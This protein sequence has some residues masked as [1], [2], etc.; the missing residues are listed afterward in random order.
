MKKK[1]YLPQRGL[2]Y[3]QDGGDIS[4]SPKREG[5]FTEFA[6]SIGMD[7]QAAA[8]HV[9][10]HKDKYSPMRVK[11]ANFARNAAKFKHADG[12]EAH[13]PGSIFGAYHYALPPALALRLTGMYDVP[14]PDCEPYLPKEQYGGISTEG[15]RSNSPDRF[16]PYNIIPSGNISM[17]N[18]PHPVFG[19]DNMGTQQMMYPGGEYQFPGQTVFELPMR[20]MGGKGKYQQG[21]NTSPALTR[22]YVDSVFNANQNLNWVNRYTHPDN[23]PKINNP[24]GSYSTHMMV[25]SDNMVYP[26][27]VQGSDGKLIKLNP[28]DAYNYA[29]KTGTF[30]KFPDEKDAIEFARNG[31]KAGTQYKRDGARYQQGGQFARKKYYRQ[32]GGS[33]ESQNAMNNTNT[34]ADATAAAPVPAYKNPN[35]PELSN[36]V[37][38]T[39]Y[40]DYAI[41]SGQSPIGTPRAST[42]L[43]KASQV[44]GS[45]D[46]ARKLLDSIH[47]FSQRNDVAKL[48]PA[49][50]IDL[51]YNT[52]HSNDAD[53]EKFKSKVKTLGYSP[54]DYFNNS[55]DVDI[56]KL[57]NQSRPSNLS[58]TDDTGMVHLTDLANYNIASGSNPLQN[59]YGRIFL[60]SAGDVLGKGA[61][62]KMMDSMYLFSQRDDIK[63]LSPQDRLNLYY[64]TLNSSDSDVNAFKD[65]VKKLGTS[66]VE[67]FKE[68]P[69]VAIQALL[70]KPVSPANTAGNTI[71]GTTPYRAPGSFQMGGE[72][73]PYS[74]MYIEGNANPF[75]PPAPDMGTEQMGMRSLVGRPLSLKPIPFAGSVRNISNVFP[76]PPS[77]IPPLPLKPPPPVTHWG[78]NIP[79]AG[80]IVSGMS[81][82]NNALEANDRNRYKD[83][84]RLRGM[85]DS[86]APVMPGSRGDY[87]FNGGYFRPNQYVPVQ[88]GAMPMAQ[89]GGI[90]DEPIT[91]IPQLETPPDVNQYAGMPMGQDQ[92]AGMP[93]PPMP[94]RDPSYADVP[95][96][97]T[98]GIK[99]NSEARNAFN[100]YVNQKKLSPVVAAGIVGNLFWESGLDPNARERGN[101]GAGRGIAQ[102]AAGDR[103]QGFQNWA[104]KNG[105]KPDLDAQLDYVLAEPGESSKALKALMK[106]N[107]PEQ[108][109]YIFGK[110]YE[111]PLDKKDLVASKNPARW[112]MRAGAARLLFD[113]YQSGNQPRNR[114]DAGAGPYIADNPTYAPE[115]DAQDAQA[116]Y[117]MGGIVKNKFMPLSQGYQEGGEY[118]VTPSQLQFIL[119]HG[120]EV[121]FL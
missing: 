96:A 103:W 121:E 81:F 104:K 45:Q 93:M 102:W 114:V 82:L 97:N 118:M 24:D 91:D 59:T 5:K 86:F 54:V 110:T 53:T 20:R 19:M 61:T 76:S 30:I 106:A 88:Y 117:R 8:A 33:V 73:D 71:A 37:R 35:T 57:A 27:I 62:Q 64:N 70:N 13:A 9:L 58:R 101:T 11:Q 119:A 46:A 69:D 75:L 60:N 41:G 120:G 18:V 80:A 47:L 113:A 21:G 83:W 79:A 92:S 12:G 51:F 17:Q 112:D 105:R 16:N 23:Y 4:I 50:R 43:D 10:A 109:S 63:N 94:S 78:P 98:K 65:K 115:G 15:Y 107:T 34:N 52:L 29:Q 40:A 3:Y 90:F 116:S 95:T 68:S 111:R 31:Y 26:T 28:D 55:P 74:K 14:C 77:S 42:F 2:N 85:S 32:D 99:L 108:A 44:M 1:N 67:F 89:M 39:D 66:P 22:G 87:S 84:A 36:L 7:V 100:Y 56:I 25:S 38:L 48:S 72:E 49:E 6:R